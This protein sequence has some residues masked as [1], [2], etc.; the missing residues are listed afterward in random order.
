MKNNLLQNELTSARTALT[1]QRFNDALPHLLEALSLQPDNPDLILLAADTFRRCGKITDAAELYR[2]ATLQRPGFFAAYCNLGAAERELGNIAAA[3]AALQEAIRLNPESVEALCNLGMA[4][5]QTGNTEEALTCFHNAIIMQ[6][7]QPFQRIL[8]AETAFSSGNTDDAARVLSEGLAHNPKNTA[9]LMAKGRLLLTTEQLNEARNTFIDA[10]QINPHLAEAHYALGTIMREWKQ[11]DEAILC[12]QNALQFN[13]D[14]INTLVNIGEVCQR[15][16]LIDESEEYF[17]KA[18][19]RAPDCR[20][21]LHNLLVSITYN[22]RH[23]AEDVIRHHI[24]F[25]KN[26][27][28]SMPSFIPHSG[29]NH[30]IRIGYLSPDFCNHPAAAFLF[31]MLRFSNRNEFEIFC[32]M[33]NTYTDTTTQALRQHADHWRP[34][35]H[36]DDNNCATCI[37]A[38]SIDILIDTAGHF[39]GNRFEVLTLRVAPLQIAG[40]GYPG[41]VGT[42]AIDYRISDD[43]IDPP[44]T[45]ATVPDTPLRLSRCFCCYTPPAALPAVAPLPAWSQNYITFGSLHTTARLNRET[46][47][48]WSDALSMVPGSRMFIF[49]DTLSPKIIARLTTWF[50]DC[51]ISADRLS[52]QSVVPAEGHLHLYNSIDITLDTTPWSGHTTA[53]ESLIMGVPVV[54]LAGTRHAGRMVASVLHTVG[55]N[56]WIAQVPEDFAAIANGH[57]AQRAALEA[58]RRTLRDRVLASPLCDGAAYTAELEKYFVTLLTS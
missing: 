8:Y 19:A 16:G 17:R 51:N 31:P 18:L 52:F 41:P 46:I 40:I 26:E 48:L 45:D 38:N 1:Q 50:S 7:S 27:H 5:R 56:D 36:L 42:S 13:P 49:R 47:R 9:L 6:P 11:L 2:K 20:P 43:V 4:F 15:S 22:N 29:K 30:R 53:C 55:L 37:R 54:T 34:V 57:A 28:H 14:D 12:Y 44:S 58:L 39:T 21:A 25:C 3:V 24:Q 33:Q 32:Y 10:L 23:S 35:H